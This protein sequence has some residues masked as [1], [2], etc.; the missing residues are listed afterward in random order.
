MILLVG[1]GNPGEKYQHNRHNVGHQFVDFIV[2]SSEFVVRSQDFKLVKSNVFMND[3]GSFVQ[4][5]TTYYQLSTTNLYILH[6]DLDL[7][8]GEYK[9]QKGVGPKVHYGLNSVEKALGN[10]DF[11]R[12]RIG[13]DNRDPDNRTPGEDYVLQNF[14]PDEVK[15][16][17][18]LFPKIWEAI[19]RI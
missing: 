5:L 6:D 11:W 8:L 13:V 10:K 17:D 18:K 12:V 14:S 7:K 9:I 16:L 4:K 15:M 1:L 2:G 19:C 3:S